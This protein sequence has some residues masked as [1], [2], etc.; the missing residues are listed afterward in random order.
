M[1]DERDPWRTLGLQPGASEAEIRRAYRRLARRYHPDLHPDEPE[2]EERFKQVQA[3]YEALTQGGGR[4]EHGRRPF[5]GGG[6]PHPGGADE[7]D[8]LFL[9][10]LAAY[11]RS[12]RGYQG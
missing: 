12:R 3:A 7:S 10:I 9:E 5:R 8:D 2:A 6:Q 1:L 4:P 11:L